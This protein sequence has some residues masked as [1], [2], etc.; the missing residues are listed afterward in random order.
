MLGGWEVLYQEGVDGQQDMASCRAL[1]LLFSRAQGQA[2]RTWSRVCRWL[3]RLQ[4]GDDSFFHMCRFALCGRVSVREFR[5]NLNT[6]SGRV[7]IE[8]D[9]R[10]GALLVLSFKGWFWTVRLVLWERQVLVSTAL[11]CF[12]T[13]LQSCFEEAPGSSCIA[14]MTSWNG[15]KAGL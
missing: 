6:L 5:A 7:A 9:H 3:Q 10:R 1:Y 13:R 2:F 8:D 14:V 11:T 15:L 4:D 12:F